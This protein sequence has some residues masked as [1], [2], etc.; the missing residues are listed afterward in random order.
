M[1][2]SSLFK[3][4]S[5]FPAFYHLYKHSASLTKKAFFRKKESSAALFSQIFPLSDAIESN[6]KLFYKRK[7][8]TGRP[9]FNEIFARH[10]EISAVY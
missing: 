8:I 1:N 2:Q 5:L 7:S 3:V 4:F 10:R 6:L 9:S